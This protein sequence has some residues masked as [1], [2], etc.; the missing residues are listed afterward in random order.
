[1]L[2][3]SKSNQSAQVFVA[4]GVSP[5]VDI[6][7]SSKSHVMYRDALRDF[8]EESIVSTWCMISGENLCAAT[9]KFMGTELRAFIAILPTIFACGVSP[10]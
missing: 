8:G 5:A 1:M 4:E 2:I 6:P 7:V 3:Y 10:Q 9:V